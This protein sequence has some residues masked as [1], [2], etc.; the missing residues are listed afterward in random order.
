MKPAYLPNGISRLLFVGLLLAYGAVQAQIE[1]VVVTASKRGAQ[2]IQDIPFSVQSLTGEKLGTMGVN[3]FNDFFRLVPGLSV[4]DQGPGDKRIILRG[5]NATGAG[6]VGLYLDEVIITG[7]NAQ[8][9]GGRQPDIKLFDMDRLEVLKGPQ[10]TTFGSSSLS[11]TIRYITNKPNLERFEV[12]GKGTVRD[13]K[14]ADISGQVEAA[15]NLPIIEDKLA[16][17]VAGLYL[18]N[19]GFIDNMFGK[20]VNSDETLAG[21]VSLLYKPTDNLSLSL[22]AMHQSVETDGPAYFNLVDAGG[23]PLPPLTQSDLSSNPFDD[24]ITLYNA[25]LEYI[26]SYGTFTG[27]VSRYERDTVF[28]RDA[29][30]VVGPNSVITQ[31]KDREVNSYEVRFA[32]AW[33]LPLQALVGF[34]AQDEERFFQSRIFPADPV[35][36]I[37]SEVAGFSLDRNVRTDIDEIAFFAELSLDITDSLNLTGGFR[38][39]DIDVKEI[40]NAVQG[41]SGAPGAGIGPTLAFGEEG[42]I[43][44]AN[45]SY[46]F[47]DDILLYAQWSQGF[48]SG[49][50]NDQTA[51]QI[52]QVTIPAGFG[53][54]SLDN[55]ELGFKT[56]WFDGRLIANG[57]FYFIDWSDIQIQNRAQDPNNPAVFFPFRGNGGAADIYGIEFDIT[58]RPIDGLELGLAAS[59]TDAKLAEDNPVPATGMKGDKI[60]YIPETTLTFTGQ[61]TRPL[62]YR[63]LSGLFGVDVT[64][65]NDRSTELRPT[66]PF[67][68]NLES[69]TLVNLRAG[70]EADSWSA[71]LSVNNVFND[72][73]VI[74]VFRIIPGLIPDGFIPQRPRSISFSVS[75]SFL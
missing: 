20:G 8:D 64:Y 54:D 47:N 30:V 68:L 46:R 34:F 16:I 13:I 71:I 7:E 19:D 37:F 6:T 28:N 24:E 29:S 33:N 22:M 12:H 59:W 15:V 41:F 11:G 75:K 2:N 55:Y 18:N 38:W 48:R 62:P 72:D 14:G 74:D 43:G 26:N 10:G 39:F 50:T 63:N 42:V 58:A 5:V 56:S 23:N 49:G 25:T 4:F 27:T 67:N 69:Y 66:N 40:A 57:A 70:V 61:Y 35:T 60:P 36:G 53:S 1:E 52:A 3:D 21:R 31:P 51:A 44:K 17:R 65:V 73:S 45:L 9:G 32:S